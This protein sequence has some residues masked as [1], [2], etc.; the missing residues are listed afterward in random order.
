M[1]MDVNESIDVVDALMTLRYSPAIAGWR[2]DETLKLSTTALIPSKLREPI[3][4]LLILLP[5][6][7][8][9]NIF[10]FCFFFT[11]YFTLLTFFVL[12]NSKNIARRRLIVVH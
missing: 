2:R 12:F 8:M 4:D 1:V 11:F 6:I 3:N 5:R 7:T 9:Q 10:L